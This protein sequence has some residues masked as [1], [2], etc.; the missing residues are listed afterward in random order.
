MSKDTINVDGKD[1]VVREDTAKA[2]R[3]VN[4]ALISIGA[5]IIILGVVFAIFFLGAAS[6]GEIN[7]PAGAGNG[8]GPSSR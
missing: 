5:F 8:T 1:V 3:G 7:T 2:Y 4:W 6:D